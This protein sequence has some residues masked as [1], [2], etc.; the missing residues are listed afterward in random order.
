MNIY[1]CKIG[2]ILCVNNQILKQME[3]PNLHFY[4]GCLALISVKLPCFQS[5]LSYL[6]SFYIELFQKPICYEGDVCLLSRDDEMPLQGLQI[7]IHAKEIVRGNCHNTHFLICT[8]WCLSGTR[9][10]D[11]CELQSTL[12]YEMQLCLIKQQCHIFQEFIS[13]SKDCQK[14]CSFPFSFSMLASKHIFVVN[15]NK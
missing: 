7:C 15:Q 4:F 2:L 6:V 9:A 13:Q 14:P 11:F 3:K 10:R 12:G 1:F 8:P 5:V